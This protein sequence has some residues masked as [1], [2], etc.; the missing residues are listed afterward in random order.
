M[1]SLSVKIRQSCCS[2]QARLDI[3]TCLCSPPAAIWRSVWHGGGVAGGSCP[4]AAPPLRSHIRR[5]HRKLLG[6]RRSG[7][8][9]VSGYAEIGQTPMPVQE[10]HVLGLEVTVDYVV[11]EIHQRRHDVSKDHTR[12][13]G[14]DCRPLFFYV[15]PEILLG[16]RHHQYPTVLGFPLSR[17]GTTLRAEPRST[18]PSLPASLWR[19]RRRFAGGPRPTRPSSPE[20][21]L[22]GSS[23]PEWPRARHLP[24]DPRGRRSRRR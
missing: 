21:R 20:R 14:A 19:L 2:H 23:T 7:R 16:S 8:L 1:P 17:I 24:C 12:L 9:G 3:G 15:L 10:E 11:S 5:R 22:G 18:F 13:V 6:V 4:L